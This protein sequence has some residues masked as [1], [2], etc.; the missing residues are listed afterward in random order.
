MFA[1]R[2]LRNATK[3]S[4]LVGTVLNLINQGEHVLAGGSLMLGHALLNYLVPF[5]VASYSGAKA[6]RD[7][8]VTRTAGGATDECTDANDAQPD[9]CAEFEPSAKAASALTHSGEAGRV[10]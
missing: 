1:Q 9:S 7:T 6:L 8:E 2:I 3:V 5:C 4:L 10:R